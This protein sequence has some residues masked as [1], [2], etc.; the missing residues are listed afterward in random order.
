MLAVGAIG[1]VLAPMK[2]TPSTPLAHAEK[3]G[4]VAVAIASGSHLLLLQ[5]DGD[6]AKQ[7]RVSDAER[8]MLCSNV[9]RL[10]IADIGLQCRV[11]PAVLASVRH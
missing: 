2:T 4:D 3:S 7:Q 9:F 8:K 11:V 6:R 5:D 10:T 1:L